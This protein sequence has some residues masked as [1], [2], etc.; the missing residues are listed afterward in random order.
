MSALGNDPRFGNSSS[1]SQ[2]MPPP[3]KIRNGKDQLGQ[4]G[5]NYEVN[6]QLP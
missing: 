5:D 1:S 6:F 2:V 3:Q 4:D